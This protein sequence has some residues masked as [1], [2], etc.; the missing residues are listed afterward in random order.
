MISFCFVFLSY[1]F[2]K[3]KYYSNEHVQLKTESV[4]QKVKIIGLTS[5]GYLRAV[6][7]T[8][9]EHELHPDGNHFDL[10][11]GLIIPKF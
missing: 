7:E 4:L 8:G 6:D 10:L 1:S 5:S 2:E 11:K 3:K 9:R